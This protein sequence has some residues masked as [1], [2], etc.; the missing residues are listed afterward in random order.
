M[1]KLFFVLLLLIIAPSLSAQEI[2]ATDEPLQIA[3]NRRASF[4]D[5]KNA[6]DQI[7]TENDPHTAAEFAQIIRNSKEPIALRGY[8]ADTLAEAKN[9]WSGME[10]RKILK[11]KTAT[12]E[13]RKLALY[14][15]WK[16]EPQT[17]QT[18]LIN[19]VQNY[20]EPAELRVAALSYL[21]ES[22]E[23]QP[24]KFWLDLYARKENP[25]AIRIT[26]LDGLEKLELLAQNE[27]VLIQIIHNP[28]E[29][30][31]IRK[32]S[33][34][35]GSRILSSS[36]LGQELTKIVSN[37]ENPLEMRHFAVNHLASVADTVLVP[38]L[39]KISSQEK[40]TTL[41]RELETLI[42]NLTSK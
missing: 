19:M 28:R 12:N 35:T 13:S 42:A 18:E 9:K 14:S 25:A 30:I 26:A 11:D 2:S 3:K 22:K 1:R 8:V 38:E 33:I 23:N 34:L 7:K 39:K 40:N 5:R 20:S 6:I 16:K 31:E 17:F 32:S 27:A 36:V 41:S 4:Q 10:L 15:L 24:P 37:P 29:S 21:S